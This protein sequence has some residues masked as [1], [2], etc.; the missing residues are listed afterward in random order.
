MTILYSWSATKCKRSI[1]TYRVG[2]SLKERFSFLPSLYPLFL[3]LSPIFSGSS[4][5]FFAFLCPSSPFSC[6]SSPLSPAPSRVHILLN[7][8]EYRSCPRFIPV[9][10]ARSVLNNTHDW[11]SHSNKDKEFHVFTYYFVLCTFSLLIFISNV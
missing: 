5:N 3:D 6:P 2:H 4:L 11:R 9:K 1:G 7:T 10:L 8:T